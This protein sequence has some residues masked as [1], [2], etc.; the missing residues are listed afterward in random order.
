MR[1]PNNAFKPTPLRSTTHMAGR[2]CHMGCS[3]TRRGLTQALG[4]VSRTVV[5]RVLGQLEVFAHPL[6]LHF[7]RAVSASAT[8]R[9]ATRLRTGA[10][11]AQVRSSRVGSVMVG[12]AGSRP[13]ARAIRLRPQ[14]AQAR[15]AGPDLLYCLAKG[16]VAVL[17]IGG[18]T[19]HSSRC[20]FAA[21]LNSG[22]RLQWSRHDNSQRSRSSCK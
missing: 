19:S 5:A 18:L 15:A 17:G 9:D 11:S 22:V 16:W 13:R 21:R 12:S 3:T 14:Q 20:R 1:G 7:A 6:R 2:A 4:F 10:A 8:T